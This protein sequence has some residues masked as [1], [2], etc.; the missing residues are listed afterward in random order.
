MS[1]DSNENDIN[2]N[3]TILIMKQQAMKANVIND[4]ND[5]Q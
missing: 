5:N 3:E 1:N 4:I 2:S